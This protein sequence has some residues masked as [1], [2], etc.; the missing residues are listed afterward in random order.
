MDYGEEKDPTCHHTKV[1]FFI[2]HQGLLSALVDM[3]L[4]RGPHVVPHKSRLA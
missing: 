2:E 1:K 3:Q 4:A